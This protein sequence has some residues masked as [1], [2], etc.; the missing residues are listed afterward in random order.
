MNNQ[1]S[2]LLLGI[3]LLLYRLLIG[4]EAYYVPSKQLKVLPELH[5]P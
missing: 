2:L 1:L 3:G 4:L 5:T